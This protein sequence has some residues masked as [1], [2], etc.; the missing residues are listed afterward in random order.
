MPTN[1]TTKRR[2]SLG[3]H[4]SIFATLFVFFFRGWGARLRAQSHTHFV[5]YDELSHGEVQ[6]AQHCHRGATIVTA[7]Y[8]IGQN[9]KHS[10][11]KFRLWNR[12]FFGLRD[13]MVVFTDALTAKQIGD[14]RVRTFGCSIL[15]ISDLKHSELWRAYDWN[16]QYEKDPEKSIHSSELYVIWNQKSLWLSDV[17]TS[18]PFSSDHF[19]WADS[20]QF[21]DDDFL[22]KFVRKNGDVWLRTADWF[23]SCQILF[24]SVES[25]TER[26]SQ[27]DSS[28]RSIILDSKLVRLGGGNFGG[29]TCAIMRWRDLF[30]EQLERYVVSG[31]FA[32]K[33]Q[34]IYGTTCLQH[35]ELCFLVDGRKVR[36]IN[37]VWF[38]MQPVL[39]GVQRPLPRY[40]P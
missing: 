27:F 31:A 38:A 34:P 7:Y 23:P 20:G 1:Y 21:R 32:G 33:D 9:S 16:S 25:F 30:L 10:E 18:N 15:V 14:W 40:V 29:D 8:N 37:D 4:C 35:R 39:H 13:S 5:T 36:D 12:R 6:V 11:A 24:L 28:G 3:R 19:F 2:R 26:E 22:N 17:A